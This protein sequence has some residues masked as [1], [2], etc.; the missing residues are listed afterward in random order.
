MNR[1][2]TKVKCRDVIVGT[3]GLSISV[4]TMTHMTICDMQSG[5]VRSLL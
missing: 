4:N 2:Y 3:R 5:Q 1:H